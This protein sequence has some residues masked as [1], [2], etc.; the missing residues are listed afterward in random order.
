[1][2]NNFD[3][4]IILDSLA[5]SQGYLGTGGRAT[6]QSVGPR[7]SGGAP[8]DPN[9]VLAAPQGSLHMGAGTLWQNT[10]GAATW[11]ALGG[12]GGSISPITGLLFVDGTYSGPTPPDGSIAAPFTTIQD[13]LDAIGPPTTV[14]EQFQGWKVVISANFYDEDLVIPPQR[15]IVLDCAPGS[16]LADTFPPTTPRKITWAQTQ[17]PFIPL[18]SFGLEINNLIMFDGIELIS[19]LPALNPDLGLRLNQVSFVAL[20]GPF[21]T[22]ASIDATGL[23]VGSAPVEVRDCLVRDMG[24]TGLC[25]NAGGNNAY[26][27]YANSSEF[28]A[29]ISA[30]G[31]GQ[32]VNSTFSGDQT[33]TDQASLG[34]LDRPEGFFGCQFDAGTPNTFTMTV[35]GLFFMDGVTWKS[36]ASTTFV[37]TTVQSLDDEY[38]AGNTPAGDATWA[39]GGDNTLSNAID[40]I[41]NALAVSIGG[42]IP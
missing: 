33:Y 7:L 20:P 4:P 25:F 41:A 19:G 34:N 27:S 36:C 15:S 22:I 18:E 17:T 2:S 6:D 9:L 21:G 32:M 26:L 30:S 23:T 16:L 37:G 14:A 42:P 29:S 3:G 11:V 12:G 35:A 39:A 8:A 28:D 38:V 31:Y 24:A 1:M 5:L 40:R 13:A 10:D